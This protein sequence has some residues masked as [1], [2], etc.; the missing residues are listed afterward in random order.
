MSRGKRVSRSRRRRSRKVVVR[1]EVLLR[2]PT[3]GCPICGLSVCVCFFFFVL[4]LCLFC[5]FVC[6]VALFVLVYFLGARNF[7]YGGRM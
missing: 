5:C 6:F 7:F 1:E 4:L 2:A 3:R